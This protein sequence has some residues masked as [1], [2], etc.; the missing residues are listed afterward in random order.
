MIE[1]R[2]Q[3]DII[4]CF[5]LYLFVPPALVMRMLFGKKVIARLECSGRYGDFWRIKQLSYGK[6]VV[7][8]AKMLDA[9]IYISKEIEREL[10]ANGFPA[11]KLKHITNC[12]DVR[13]FIPADD[14]REESGN[15]ICFVG[16]LEEQKGLKYLIKAVVC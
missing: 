10:L 13:Q 2:K 7:A 6:M 11:G 14:L 4:Q 8:S 9:I 12:V 1:H 5:G 15:E 16:R 3:Y